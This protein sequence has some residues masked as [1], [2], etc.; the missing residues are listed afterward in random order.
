MVIIKY[1]YNIYTK[2]K[3]EEKLHQTQTYLNMK[4]NL[5]MVSKHY[6][7]PNADSIV[8][9]RLILGTHLSLKFKLEKM[10]INFLLGSLNVAMATNA[11]TSS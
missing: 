8:Q 10:D 2:I 6:Y 3:W 7:Q 4:N 1:D 5:L 11:S 9:K